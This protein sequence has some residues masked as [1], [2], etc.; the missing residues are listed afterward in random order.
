MYMYFHAT[1]M[2]VPIDRHKKFLKGGYDATE[3][4]RRPRRLMNFVLCSS[5]RRSKEK[6][7]ER[8]NEEVKIKSGNT[9]QKGQDLIQIIIKSRF[10]L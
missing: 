10:L 8:A 2:S 7:K 1:P 4:A 5:P 6:P 3:I 9:L